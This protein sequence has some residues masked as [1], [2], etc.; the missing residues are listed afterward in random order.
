MEH[1]SEAFLM[2]SESVVAYNPI[3]ELRNAVRVPM[4]MVPLY[5]DS[6]AY[7]VFARRRH[8]L[9]KEVV[10]LLPFTLQVWASL[11]SLMT[12][13][14]ITLELLSRT[15][16]Y[17]EGREN[18]SRGTVV[19]PFAALLLQQSCSLSVTI[20]DR[21]PTQILLGV[22]A[23]LAVVVGTA[24]RGSLTSLLRQVPLEGSPLEFANELDIF[25][26]GYTFCRLTYQGDEIQLD[27]VKLT[28]VKRMERFCLTRN[29]EVK[30]LMGTKGVYLLHEPSV[31]DDEL[32]TRQLYENDYVPLPKRMSSYLGG[33]SVR[34]NS[35]YRGAVKDTIIQAFECGLFQREIS[36]DDYGKNYKAAQVVRYKT[37]IV[38][39]LTVSDLKGGLSF[40]AFGL[41]L[42]T[43]CLLLEL[44]VSGLKSI[45]SRRA[46]AEV[47]RSGQIFFIRTGRN[48]RV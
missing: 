4:V 9:S 47:R 14:V 33:P 48:H 2:T 41:V 31:K 17:R 28:P 7:S 34:A 43:L 46:A 13:C 38:I 22:W 29:K 42:A 40:V 37:E 15:S 6:F 45:L 18:F 8:P 16:L 44:V 23:L 21:T 1:V 12:I 5:Y 25:R 10:I 32:Y 39:Y 30:Y 35:R 19:L 36:L 24:F 20:R 3:A 27:F 11:L 26:Q